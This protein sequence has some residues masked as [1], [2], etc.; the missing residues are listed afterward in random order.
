MKTIVTEKVESATS[1][2]ELLAWILDANGS[3]QDGDIVTVDTALDYET[4]A[5]EC[6]VEVAMIRTLALNLDAIR[7]AV[8]ADLENL[9]RRLEKLED[10]C[11]QGTAACR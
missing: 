2:L 6:G 11:G 9:H 4:L 10:R 8:Q 5:E 3:T 7:E 1:T